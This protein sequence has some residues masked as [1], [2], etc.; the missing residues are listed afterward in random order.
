MSVSIVF[1]SDERFLFTPHLLGEIDAT[2]RLRPTRFR[3]DRQN[4]HW[5]EDSASLP[6]AHT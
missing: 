1:L 3:R 2:G 4:Q 5:A 6:L